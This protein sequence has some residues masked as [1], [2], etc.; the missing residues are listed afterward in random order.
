[1]S[2]Q[3]REV[4]IIINHEQTEKQFDLPWPAHE[5][6]VGIDTRELQLESYG[7]AVVTRVQKDGQQ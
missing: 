1:V 7:V 2:A 3:G 6:L 4:F 5:H